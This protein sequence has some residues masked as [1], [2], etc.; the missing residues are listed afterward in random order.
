[1]QHNTAIKILI[2]SLFWI[3]YIV[4]L[5]GFDPLCLGGLN[6][7]WYSKI[8]IIL[9]LLVGSITYLNDQLLLPYFFKRKFY[10]LYALITFGL[11]FLTTYFYCYFVL[12][13]VD[14]M[15][16]CF[17]DDFWII[18]LPVV[19]L[20]LVW[21]ILA[22]F[23]KQKELEK[24]HSDRVELELKFLKAQINPHVLFN[25]LNTIYSKAVKENEGIAE[26]ILM[27]SEN[28]KYVLNQS[29]GK[30]VDLEDDLAFIENYLS[31]QEMR[32][33]GI[34]NI[35]YTKE[36]DSYN[37]SIAPLILIDFIENA[38]KYSIYK[39]NELSDID[40]FIKIQDGNLQFVCKNEYKDKLDQEKEM[41]TQIGIQN[42]KQRLELIYKNN[43]VLEINNV[44][45]V[46][47]VTLNIDLK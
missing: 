20:S 25:S 28:L 40:I 37:Y 11:L 38:F 19:F 15:V 2:H 27:L 44:N 47:I 21:V 5:F 46:F 35:I 36:I 14:S 16:E 8:E 30:L 41:A 18:A 43:Y 29:K 10:S 12:G 9:L 34:N 22:F 42:I 45:G 3:F 31:F 26:M 17:S 23:E 13:C 7:S 32:T 33:Q 24:A 39:N 4:V 1:M 6:T